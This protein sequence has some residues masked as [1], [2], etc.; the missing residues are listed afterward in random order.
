MGLE[1][2]I[3]KLADLLRVPVLLLDPQL[4]CLPREVMP[5]EVIAVT[6]GQPCGARLDGEESTCWCKK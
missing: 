1:P 4:K 6:C 2:M 3:Q 5:I